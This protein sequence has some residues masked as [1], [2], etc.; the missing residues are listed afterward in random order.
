M[1]TV[2]KE[3]CDCMGNVISGIEKEDPDSVMYVQ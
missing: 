3:K 1:N 2:T